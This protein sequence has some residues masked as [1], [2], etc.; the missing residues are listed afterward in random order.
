MVRH[1]ENCI[2]VIPEPKISAN[3]PS[4]AVKSRIIGNC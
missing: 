1:K 3:L 4:N 2:L